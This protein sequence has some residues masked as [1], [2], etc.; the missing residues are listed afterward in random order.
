MSAGLAITTSDKAVSTVCV[1]RVSS[2]GVFILN[3]R[4]RVFGFSAARDIKGEVTRRTAKRITKAQTVFEAKPVCNSKVLRCF[5]AKV[6]L[7]SNRFIFFSL[8]YMF[9][10][11]LEH[12][13]I[14]SLP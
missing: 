12:I 4:T 2:T 14:F 1:R 6:R 7:K 11:E 5:S 9:I 10:L 3:G 13:S 8:F